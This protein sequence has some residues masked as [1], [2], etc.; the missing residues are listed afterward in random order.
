[1]S[2]TARE[3]KRVE[4]STLYLSAGVEALKNARA[5]SGSRTCVRGEA[6]VYGDG[7][8]LA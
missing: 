7:A 5:E 1:M 2:I 4:R 6:G 8:D 3:R